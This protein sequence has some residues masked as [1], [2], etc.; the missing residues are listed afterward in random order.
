VRPDAT[1]I[2]PKL[3]WHYS[4]PYADSSAV[5]TY[6]LSQLTRQ[7][8]TVALNGDAGDENFAGYDRYLANVLGARYR[9]LPRVV[10]S[11]M[12][13][14]VK[15]IPASGGP[16]TSLSRLKRLFE[17]FAE[18]TERRYA[19]WMMHFHPSLKRH[20][21]TPA[22][23]EA[24][25]NRDS[26]EII[27]A[28][29]ES[30]DA[31]NL[32]DATLDVD[33]NSYLPDDL[34][35]KVDIATM[36]HGLEGRSPFLDH[37]FMEFAAS[38]PADLKLRGRTKKYLLKRAARQLL[39]D[40]IIDRPKMGFG[41]PLDHWFR[42]D[43]KAMAYDL[44]LGPRALGRGYFRPDFVKQLLDEHVQGTR[45]WHYQLWNLTML[46]LWHRTF[47]D[48]RPDEADAP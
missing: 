7:H 9:R 10:Q 19:R 21:C 22:F 4:E 26:V 30:S 33:V 3:V 32:V 24:S 39:P 5:P 41:V 17:G 18:P 25:G 43:L 27:T 31:D 12:Q 16:R 47:I 34:L 23:L 42:K 35:V 37:E 45:N 13:A 11:S 48:G 15:R 28:A 1:A 44:L 14:L 8:V 29:Y 40:A 6:Y 2:V 46:E 38:L 36:A 20:L